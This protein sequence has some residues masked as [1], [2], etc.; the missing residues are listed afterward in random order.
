MNATEQK[1]KPLIFRFY[2]WPL[3]YFVGLLIG[4]T[5][6][7]I[8]S[9]L[10]SDLSTHLEPTGLFL[11]FGGW[12]LLI[13]SGFGQGLEK[14]FNIAP[15]TESQRW[16][17]RLS[18]AFGLILNVMAWTLY[19]IEENTGRTSRATQPLGADSLRRLFVTTTSNP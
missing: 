5:V 8:S 2:E 4:I 12:V 9:L 16:I 15:S 11:F 13:A 14:A 1:R 6:A 19:T 7:I 10:I 17:C 18:V 3:S